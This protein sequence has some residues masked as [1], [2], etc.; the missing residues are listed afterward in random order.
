V[1]ACRPT[2]RLTAR[3]PW[4]AVIRAAC[5]WPGS[6]RRKKQRSPRHTG[7]LTN[8]VAVSSAIRAASSGR[9]GSAA[10]CSPAS[11][12]CAASQA[13]VSALPVSSSQR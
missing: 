2:D 1:S 5:S 7:L 10:S 3:A 4:A 12:S 11:V 13:R 8:P 6:R 9:A